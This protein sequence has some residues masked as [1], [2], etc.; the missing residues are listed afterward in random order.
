MNTRSS[1]CA[2]HE[3]GPDPIVSDSARVRCSAHPQGNGDAF[4][5]SF[6]AEQVAVIV[7]IELGELVEPDVLESSGLV[8]VAV[9]RGCQVPEA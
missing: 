8:A 1:A 4:F 5:R 7:F 6:P 9:A 2:V 3:P